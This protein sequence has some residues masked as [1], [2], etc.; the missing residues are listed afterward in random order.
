[1]KFYSLCL[2]GNDCMKN[3]DKYQLQKELKDQLESRKQET[4]RIVFQEDNIIVEYDALNKWIYADWKGYQ[5]ED[6]IKFGCE[7]ITTAFKT[8][9]CSKIINDNTHVLGI[10]TPAANWVGK[11][12]LPAL[13]H[14]GLKYLAWVYSPGNMGRISTD[15]TLKITPVPEMVHTFDDLQS[16]KNWLKKM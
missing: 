6:S 5:T 1:M 9:S 7:K 2:P 13:K 14:L 8:F 16:A 10:W 12:W 4:D 3:I 15:E 11:E